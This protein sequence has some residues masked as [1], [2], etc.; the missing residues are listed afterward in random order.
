MSEGDQADRRAE[1][2]LQYA[3]LTHRLR[4]G[5]RV[6]WGT[7]RLVL[8]VAGVDCERL[9][10]DVL[11]TETATVAPG[12]PCPLEC[13]GRLI[14]YYTF[15]SNISDG[16]ADPDVHHDPAAKREEA[17][18]MGINIVTYALMH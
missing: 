2:R 1:A 6:P 4:T 9:V 18:R 17:I 3:V 14:V 5:E 8:D 15:E 11:T 7:I 13:E 16:W 10:R 12:D